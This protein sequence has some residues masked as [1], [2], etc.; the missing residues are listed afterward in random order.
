MNTD[1]S[2]IA[3]SRDYPDDVPTRDVGP[4]RLMGHSSNHS[5][6]GIPIATTQDHRSRY[7][8]HN[9]RCIF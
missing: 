2:F 5:E 8:I 1:L 9:S 7:K 6:I 3:G 4:D